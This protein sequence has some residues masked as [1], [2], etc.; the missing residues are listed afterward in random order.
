MGRALARRF[1][2]NVNPRL[3]QVLRL[4]Q[5]QPRR[6]SVK[7]EC[8]ESRKLFV[9]RLESVPEF[10]THDVVQFGDSLV[11]AFDGLMG[12]GHLLCQER[13]P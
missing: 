9:D 13:V 8:K 11:Q 12:V 6:P 1:G 10:S 2:D 7:K 5:F 3:G 4:G